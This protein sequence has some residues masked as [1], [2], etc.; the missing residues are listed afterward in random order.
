[1]K[2]S[3]IYSLICMSVVSAM[4]SCSDREVKAPALD[5]SDLDTTV[6]PAA[7]FYKYA[8]GGWAAKHPL[9]AQYARYGSFDKLGEDNEIR[10]N[11]LFSS[12]LEMSPKAGSVDQK[13]VDLYKQGLDSVRLNKEGAEPLQAGLAEILAISDKDALVDKIASLMHE[14]T[15]VF[16]SA[17]VSSDLIDSDNQVLY[18]GQCGLGIGDRD[19]YIDSDKQDIR[20][21]YVSMLTKFFEYAKVDNAAV[22]ARHTLE[23]ET[24]LAGICWTKEQNRDVENLYHPMSSDEFLSKYSDFD[25]EKI[26]KSFGIGPQE[27]LIVEQDTFLAAMGKY[28]QKEELAKLVDYV[29]A[30]YINDAA[31]CLSDDFL[32]ANF[33]FYKR[34]MRG[35]SEPDPRWKRA[36]R[37]TNGT[38]GEAVGQMYVA[39][40]FP[41]SSKKKVLEMVH[42]L[43]AAL[44]MR[45]DANDWMTDSTKAYAKDKL[46]AFTVKIGYPDKW[47]DYSTLN[48]DPEK[49]YFEN[50]KAASVW[51]VADNI[52]KLGTKTDRDEWFMTPQTVN[53]YYN[54]TTNEICFPAGILQYP[55]FSPDA[56]D[57][58][59]YGA[60]G[61]V[62]GHE[63]THGFD[64]Q[65][66]LF[67]K[68]GNMNSWWTAADAEA[69]K[70]KTK[71]L[72]EQYNSIEVL[73]GLHANGKYSL[74]ENIADQGGVS[75]S[76]TAL[77]NSWNGKRPADVDGF[78]P[79][80][81]FFLAFA[82]VWAGNITDEEI[83]HRTMMDSHSLSV[84]RVNGTLMNF[85]EFFDAFSI[86]EGDPMW[87]PADER[88][89]IW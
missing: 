24:A 66:R 87:R 21:G 4:T 36:M 52:S 77:K 20:D 62:I 70:A 17:G 5:L 19:Y 1:M 58:V 32:A 64:D 85:Q 7:N 65:G 53:A 15:G 68:V 6:S 37:V 2:K 26:F 63:M 38:L 25:F 42:N 29:A 59:N 18:V 84:N 3:T 76:L 46:S 40:Y 43:Q 16:F 9:P 45:I 10:V 28:F 56:D 69:F 78:S 8:T 39:K 61:V 35:I 55:F 82:R 51:Y 83:R 54:P 47:K 14:G 60:I 71:V 12:M 30:T 81:R 88:I 73:P 80:Q 23:V 31:G 27:K 72:E 79:E 86:K 34:Q 33:D 22:R 11:E 57:A 75:I 49:S 44:A 48:I 67:D 89:M 41:E 50:L 74:G 13:I